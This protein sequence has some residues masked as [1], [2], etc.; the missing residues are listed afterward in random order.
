MGL[1]IDGCIINTFYHN[2][3]VIALSE[4]ALRYVFLLSNL[5]MEA[6]NLFVVIYRLLGSGCLNYGIAFIAMLTLHQ[7]SE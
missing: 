2:I 1:Y 3:T 7:I 4:R 6:T 5:F